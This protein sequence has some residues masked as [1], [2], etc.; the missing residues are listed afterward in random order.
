[1]ER[2]RDRTD[3]LELIISSLT[4]FALFSIP[5]WLFDRVTGVYAHLSTS[6]AVASIVAVTLLAGVSYVLAAVDE[7]IDALR[8][9]FE[10]VDVKRRRRIVDQNTSLA[11]LPLHPVVRLV[12]HRAVNVAHLVTDML[13]DVD[14]ARVRP[15]IAGRLPCQS[16][17]S[18]QV[19]A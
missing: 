4:I 17:P 5:G 9:P 2:L 7:D 8:R 12:V 10:R 11:L 1:M 6:L 16:S 19:V 15:R 3:E 14:L 18:S 13:H